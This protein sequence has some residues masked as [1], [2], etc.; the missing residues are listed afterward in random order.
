MKR[1][2]S[3]QVGGWRVVAAGSLLERVNGPHL[4]IINMSRGC[5]ESKAQAFCENMIRKY[6]K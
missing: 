6:L 3:I 4:C 5:E 1:I 2:V